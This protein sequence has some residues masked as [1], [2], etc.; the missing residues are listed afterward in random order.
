[1]V[2]GLESERE[3]R[4]GGIRSKWNELV[5]DFHSALSMMICEL[6]RDFG[7][8]EVG[9]VTVEHVTTGVSGKAHVL[10]R[11]TKKGFSGPF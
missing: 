1:M 8:C 10:P 2:S 4:G 3:N 11:H 6:F 5:I 7:G 9:R